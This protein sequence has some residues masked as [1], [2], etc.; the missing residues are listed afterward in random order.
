MKWNGQDT[1]NLPMGK[2]GLKGFKQNFFKDLSQAQ[3]G[4]ILKQRDGLPDDSLIFK[5]SPDP[6]NGQN[7]FYAILT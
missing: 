4:M 6:A 3:L 7:R 2:L 1:I 5:H